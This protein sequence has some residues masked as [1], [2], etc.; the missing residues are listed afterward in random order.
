MLRTRF[1]E[2]RLQTLAAISALIVR[3][4]VALRNESVGRELLREGLRKLHDHAILGRR[5]GKYLGHAYWTRQAIQVYI[6]AGKDLRVA[7]SSLRHE[8]A[9]PANVVIERML[10]LGDA[11]TT[12]ACAR[13]I[14]RFSRVAIITREQDNILQQ[15]Q[16]ARR[17]PDD[18]NGTDVWARYRKAGIYG[19]LTLYCADA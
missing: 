5:R 1:P 17:M 8:H 3:D 10:S 19:D 16:V 4:R 14:T 12:E 2:T 11:A 18:W 6:S 13:I 15:N 7:A 9:V